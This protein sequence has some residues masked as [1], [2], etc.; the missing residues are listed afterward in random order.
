M[1]PENEKLALIGIDTGG[2]FVERGRD[3][4]EF[5]LFTFGGAAGLHGVFLAR[6]CAIRDNLMKSLYPLGI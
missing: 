2:T 1:A 5:T 3:P 6:I 4:R